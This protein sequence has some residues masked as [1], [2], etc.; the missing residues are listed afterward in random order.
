[1][2]AAFTPGN[3]VYSGSLPRLR[4]RSRSLW[5]IYYTALTNLLYNRLE[6][7][8]AAIVPAY[9]TIRSRLAATR[10]YLWDL[11]LTPLSVTLL[12]PA[13]VRRFVELWAVEYRDK[14]YAIDYL[15]GKGTGPWYAA[16][17]WAVLALADYYL[18]VTRDFAWLDKPLAGRSILDHLEAHA[19]Q[20]KKLDRR[21]V[22]LADYGE[23][24]NL[25]EVVST[26]THEVASFNASNVYGMHL[27]PASTS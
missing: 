23:A 3:T 14:Y 1:M 19:L 24:T 5:R 15:T 18:T 16:N 7:P 6:S 9:V 13:V 11:G 12:D 4:T 21:G 2:Q 25:L 26:Y 20:W 17:N 27:S 22:G 8:W 10:V